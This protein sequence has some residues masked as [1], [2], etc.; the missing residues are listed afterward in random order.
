LAVRDGGKE[1]ARYVMSL[2]ELPVCPPFRASAPE[3]GSS[4]GGGGGG[5]AG[6]NRFGS[7]RR[8]YNARTPLL[9]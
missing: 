1:A 7:R 3:E 6:L 5:G 4:A 9:G 8:L 2:A